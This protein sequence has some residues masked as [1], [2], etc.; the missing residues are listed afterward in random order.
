MRVKVG[1]MFRMLGVIVR[2]TSL[3]GEY[4]ASL[5]LLNILFKY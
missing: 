1:S 4:F 2:G 5:D 3:V